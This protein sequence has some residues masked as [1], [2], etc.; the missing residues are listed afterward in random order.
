[1]LYR[2]GNIWHVNI[3]V[4]GKKPIRRTA[5]TEDRQEAQELHDKIAN[6]VWRTGRLGEKPRKRWEGA[7]TSYLQHARKRSLGL[8]KQRLCWLDQHLAGEFLEVI[9][10]LGDDGFSAKWDA[11]LL[12]KRGEGPIKDSTLNRYRSLVAKILKDAGIPNHKLRKYE[13]PK[14]R[15]DFLTKEIAMETLAKAPDWA[16]D[17]MLFD[18]AEGLRLDNLLGL[19]WSWLD[20]QRR[21]WRPNPDNFKNGECPELPLSEYAIKIIRRQLGKHQ[22]YVFVRD[23]KKIRY[24]EW[25]WMWGRIRPEVN[26]RPITFH[27]A[28]RKTW[29]SWMRQ[30][31]ASCEDIQDAGGWKDLTVVKNTYAHMQ[32]SHLLAH[33][34]KLAETLHEIDTQQRSPVLQVGAGKGI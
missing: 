11:V 4:R 15:K 25:Y 8:D 31:G 12:A 22:V 1:M 29:A 26:G 34:D 28:G 33:M 32:P 23:G 7:V 20:L 27:S 10:G 18:W 19:Q 30:A 2:R 14:P 21:V 3:P 24:G 5:G 6:E 17:P 16:K 9:A 13:E